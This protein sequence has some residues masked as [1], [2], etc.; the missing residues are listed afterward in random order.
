L[1]LSLFGVSSLAAGATLDGVPAV[2]ANLDGEAFVAAQAP[3][4]RRIRY[5]LDDAANSPAG[6]TPGSAT[7]PLDG[8]GALVLPRLPRRV[9]RVSLDQDHPVYAGRLIRISLDEGRTVYGRLSEGTSQ[10]RR[11]RTTLD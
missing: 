1:A 11:L 9:F 10:G 6:H 7:F 4:P 3:A 2:R 5:S 8:N